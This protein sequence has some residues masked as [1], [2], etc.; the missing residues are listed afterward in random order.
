MTIYD[1]KRFLSGEA[2]HEDMALKEDADRINVGDKPLDHDRV[3]KLSND[4]LISEDLLQA[5]LSY[6]SDTKTY[7]INDLVAHNGAIYKSLKI[8]S[9]TDP[10]NDLPNFP[11]V[12]TTKSTTD[13]T[14]LPATS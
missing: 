12:N 6:W 7:L 4:G 1:E 2:L 11:D 8:H 3:V 9:G 14:S 10:T 13:F 5:Y